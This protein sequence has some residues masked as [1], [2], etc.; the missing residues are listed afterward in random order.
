MLL[1]IVN[2]FCSCFVY[3]IKYF[4]FHSET[5]SICFYVLVVGR[6]V[7]AQ[8]STEIVAFFTK[9]ERV[10]SQRWLED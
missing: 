4:V 5:K 8:K 10:L 7:F 1:K 2:R 9:T 6:P 3:K